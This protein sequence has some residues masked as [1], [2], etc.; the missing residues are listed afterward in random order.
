MVPY[1]GNV[2]VVGLYCYVRRNLLTTPAIFLLSIPIGFVFG[3]VKALFFWIT[4]LPL[5]VIIGRYEPRVAL[6]KPLAL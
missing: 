3:A 5:N 4:L 1:A 6:K 2:A